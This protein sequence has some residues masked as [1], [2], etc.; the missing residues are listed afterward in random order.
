MCARK[1]NGGGAS[2]TK[3]LQKTIKEL[4]KSVAK[5]KKENAK[6]KKS[7]GAPEEVTVYEAAADEVR[8]SA[9]AAAALLVYS[10]TSTS[11]TEPLRPS[12]PRP[13][14]RSTPPTSPTS[15]RAPSYVSPPLFFPTSAGEYSYRTLRLALRPSY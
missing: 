14:P 11:S 1:G 15:S 4:E 10:H 3:V 7:A 9:A 12:A 2:E 13:P 5:L 8:T 6:L